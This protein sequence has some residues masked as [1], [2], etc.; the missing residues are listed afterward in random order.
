MLPNVIKKDPTDLEKS[1][2]DERREKTKKKLNDQLTN[3]KLEDRIIEVDVPVERGPMV[4]IF[5]PQGMEEMGIN[6][7][8]IFGGALSG[9]SKKRKVTVNEARTI[10]QQ[11][12]SRK[13]IDMDS[14]I[15]EALKLLRAW[16][17]K[18]KK[19]L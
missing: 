4:E 11:E 6:I 5:T 7:Q 16:M 8:E 14:V 3:G 17:M 10:F 2:L 19:S 13:L 18:N 12:E 15:K 9:R 1:L